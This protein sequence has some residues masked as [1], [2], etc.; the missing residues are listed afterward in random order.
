MTKLF[1]RRWNVTVG[2]N[3]TLSTSDL[4]IVF[5]V[6]KSLEKDPNTASIK[7]T[8]LSEGSRSKLSRK[9]MSVIL[10]AGYEGSLGTIF[11]GDSRTIDHVRDS[12]DWLTHIQCG[13][14]E[15]AYRYA[16]VNESFAANTDIASAIR[17]V[18]GSLGLNTGNLEDMLSQ[19]TAV[20]SFKHGFTAFGP[21]S[22]VL[23]T[24]L[25]AAGFQW[26]IHQGALQVR[27]PDEPVQSQVFKLTPDT[28]LLG[29][30]DHTAPDKKKKPAI[31]KV[32][33]LLNP[34]LIPGYVVAVESDGVEGE[35]IMRQVEHSGDSH[36][37]DWFTD[38]ECVA[39]KI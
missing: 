33:S 12:A 29:S 35:F 8:N 24:L 16:R 18:A 17:K 27:K 22:Q 2:D 19:G 10:Q 21:A 38:L 26:S 28:G 5:K 15:H 20:T 13:D 30:P 36:G 32:R 9:G 14:G 1:A 23:D 25:K 4:R 6:K 3:Q 7:I 34:Q 39:R 11:T 31:L 37:S